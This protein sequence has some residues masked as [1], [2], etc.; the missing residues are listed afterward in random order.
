M[1]SSFSDDWSVFSI[2]ASGRT[3]GSNV[4]PL[5]TLVAVT[6]EGTHRLHRAV[7]GYMTWLGAGITYIFSKGALSGNVPGFVTPV[8][9]LE[10]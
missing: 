4:A 8:T 6:G 1:F 5:T 9:H 2:H 10:V 7:T 3:E